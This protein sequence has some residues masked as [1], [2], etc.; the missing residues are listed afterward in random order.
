MTA[1]SILSITMKD[2][3][4]A[5]NIL[6]MQELS[7]VVVKSEKVLF[8]SK[9]SGVL[10]LVNAITSCGSEM[11][12]SSVADR[13]IGR[14]AALLCAYSGVSEV[15]AALTSK[16]GRLVLDKHDIR[17]EYHNVVPN[18]LDR[19]RVGMCPFEKLTENIESPE[20]AFLSIVQCLKPIK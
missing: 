16:P 7:L 4:I 8:T 5:R 3:V 14:A 2:L 20:Q 1:E 13:V 11:R 6:A 15:Y 12:G 18:I 17:I 9:A 19:D 10:G